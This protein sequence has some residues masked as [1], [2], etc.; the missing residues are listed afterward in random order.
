MPTWSQ[1]EVFPIIA[2]IIRQ[3]QEH[4]ERFVP[5]SEIATQ[6][7]RDRDGRKVIKEAQRHPKNNRTAE[8][9]A[10]NMVAWFGQRITQGKSEWEDKFDR[11]QI[12]KR[13]AYKPVSRTNT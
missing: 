8:Q 2:R 1:D 10:S 11:I 7:L 13:W 4:Q 6:L 5:S 12:K 9:I 3:E